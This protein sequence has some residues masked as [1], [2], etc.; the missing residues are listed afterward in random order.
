M[1]FAVFL[2][3]QADRCETDDCIDYVLSTLPSMI[4]ER[5]YFIIRDGAN[6]SQLP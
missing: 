1:I 6:A 3:R 5:K 4:H 2:I